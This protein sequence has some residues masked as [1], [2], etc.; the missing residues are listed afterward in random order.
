I[1]NLR[2]KNTAC[3]S[4][5]KSAYL[6]IN[7]SMQDNFTECKF[8]QC[9]I[10]SHRL[11]YFSFFLN[12]GTFSRI[13]CYSFSICFYYFTVEIVFMLSHQ[14]LQICTHLVGQCCSQCQINF[15]NTS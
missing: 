11:A 4:T 5:C 14:T 10:D 15:L 1:Y 12:K 7:Q 8:T 9:M 3:I 13:L 2:Y 6:N